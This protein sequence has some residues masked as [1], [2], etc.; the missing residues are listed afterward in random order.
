[1]HCCTCVLLHL[2]KSLHANT[3][4]SCCLI[5]VQLAS[6][7]VTSSLSKRDDPLGLQHLQSCIDVATLMASGPQTNTHL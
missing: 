1:M 6:S 7:L 4:V 2:S 5:P 3:W